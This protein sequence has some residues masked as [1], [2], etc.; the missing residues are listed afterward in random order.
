MQRRL[1]VLRELVMDSSYTVDAEQVADA[2]IARTWARQLV[3]ELAFRNDILPAAPAL[4]GAGMEGSRAVAVRSFRP[5]RGARS[6]R[7]TAP[8]RQRGADHTVALATRA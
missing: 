1:T 2:I 8:R 4:G 5:S 3:P 6:F 7:L